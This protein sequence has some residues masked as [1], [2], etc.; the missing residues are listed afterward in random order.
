MASHDI[1]LK[2]PL[3]PTPSQPVQKS[4]AANYCIL[5]FIIVLS[6]ALVA[7]INLYPPVKYAIVNAGYKIKSLG[8]LGNIIIILINGV[9]LMPLCVPHV[10]FTMVLSLVIRNYFE[11]V[12]LFL[13]SDLVGNVVIYNLTKRYIHDTVHSRM[14]N[15]KLYKGIGLMLSK[16]PFKFSIIIRLTILPSF[17][18]SYGLAVYDSISFAPYV[19]AG[20][21]GLIP[22]GFLEIYIFQHVK[23][24]ILSGNQGSLY[25]MMTIGM[26]LVSIAGITYLAFYTQRVLKE[27]DA[28]TQGLR[29]SHIEFEDYG[30][31][32]HGEHENINDKESH[33]DKV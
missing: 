20:F 25:R 13:L 12:T 33:H 28:E 7:L 32:H 4:K 9:I 27:I 31:S 14:K 3:E 21:I 5:G 23:N 26:V 19:T 15:S 6:M 24:D 30:R 16:N 1:V 11:A 29:D 17:M 2:Q 22:R 8:L 18:K 10:V